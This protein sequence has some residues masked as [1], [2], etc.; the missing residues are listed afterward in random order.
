MMSVPP[1]TMKAAPPGPVLRDIHLPPAPSWWPPAPGWWVLAALAVV[2]LIAALLWWRRRSAR[3]ARDRRLLAE[4][5]ALA[6]A[7]RDGEDVSVLATALHQLL[8]RAARQID[9]AA[10]T[11]QNAAWRATLASVPVEPD[12]VERL[13]Q[14]DQAI[15]RPGAAFEVAPVLQ[16]MKRWLEAML[17]QQSARRRTVPSITVEASHRANA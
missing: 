3:V 7:C 6:E 9:P 8:R 12:V 10:A 14:L 17:A 2:F 5:D 4:V 1:S 16:A 11:R 15:Y 13:M